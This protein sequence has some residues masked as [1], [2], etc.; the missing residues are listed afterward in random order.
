[1]LCGV[2]SCAGE[3]KYVTKIV[4]PEPCHIPAFPDFPAIQ[5]TEFD[6][7]DGSPAAIVFT[8][9]DAT[10]LAEWL[11]EVADWRDSVRKCTGVKEAGAKDG[12]GLGTSTPT[13]A[14][15]EPPTVHRVFLEWDSL[16]NPLAIN[17]AFGYTYTPEDYSY[18]NQ[19]K[20][21][22]QSRALPH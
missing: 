5:P 22:V 1:M 13:G 14:A 21:L 10:A 6:N 15:T 4:T 8:V 18:G 12:P 11:T 7:D 20:P 9:P 16:Y 17:T 2:S 19:S 3:T